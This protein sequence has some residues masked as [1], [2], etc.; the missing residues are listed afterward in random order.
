MPF[1][2]NRIVGALSESI[3]EEDWS[4]V[5]LILDSVHVGVGDNKN[6]CVNADKL[7]ER[8]NRRIESRLRILL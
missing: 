7:P 4:C 2:K 3:D 1:P 8:I 6:E 5:K